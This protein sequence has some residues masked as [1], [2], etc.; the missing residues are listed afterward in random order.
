MLQVRVPQKF[1]T[2]EAGKRVILGLT[3]AEKPTETL[4]SHSYK[5]TVEFPRLKTYFEAFKTLSL[6]LHI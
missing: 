5:I 3:A 1:Y 4:F 2:Q 6:F